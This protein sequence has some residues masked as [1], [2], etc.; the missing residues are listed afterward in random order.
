MTVGIDGKKLVFTY[1]CNNYYYKACCV[2]VSK[3]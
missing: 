2:F 1:G 3:Y